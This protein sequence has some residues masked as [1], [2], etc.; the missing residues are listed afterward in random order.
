[1][2]L[3][4]VLN[5]QREHVL[6]TLAGLSDEDLRRPVLPSGWS[7]LG[8]VNHLALDVEE[9]WFRAVLTGEQAAIDEVTGTENAWQVPPAAPAA[10]VIGN[11]RRQA[12]LA[13]AII[14]A[15]D[16]STAPVWWPEDRFGSLPLDNLRQLLLHVITE[17]A[18]HAGH[19]DAARELIDGK[20]WLV[21]T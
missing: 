2:E 14:T 5:G 7:M 11:Y 12:E 15:T 20:Q 18:C 6:E 8:L 16:L 19:L 1:M 4:E 13:S 3:L 9:W 21:L 17:T 10:A